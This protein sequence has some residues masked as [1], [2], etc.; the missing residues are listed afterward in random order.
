MESLLQFTREFFKA[1]KEIKISLGISSYLM[2]CMMSVHLAAGLLATS[3]QFV[4]KPMTC[5]GQKG[6]ELEPICNSQFNFMEFGHQAAKEYSLGQKE[7]NFAFYKLTNWIFIL[8]GKCEL[9]F[10]ITIIHINKMMIIIFR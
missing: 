10:T 8:I 6:I 1:G 7:L 3:Y 4:G 9:I 2:T 5:F